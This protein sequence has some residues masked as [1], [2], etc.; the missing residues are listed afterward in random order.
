MLNLEHLPLTIQGLLLCFEDMVVQIGLHSSI[1]LT[2]LVV[3]GQSRNA[4]IVCFIKDH[5]VKI[6]QFCVKVAMSHITVNN[7][8]N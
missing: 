2:A 6:H 4:L 5:D 1:T 7:V 8:T 3:K